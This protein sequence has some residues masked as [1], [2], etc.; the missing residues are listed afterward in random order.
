MYSVLI[1]HHVLRC[2]RIDLKQR[3]IKNHFNPKNNDDP[4]QTSDDD[5]KPWGEPKTL[6]D[7]DSEESE[8]QR[9]Q[10]ADDGGRKERKKVKRNAKRNCEKNKSYREASSDEEDLLTAKPRKQAKKKGESSAGMF[11]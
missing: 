7:T 1:P 3:Y 5:G 9:K 11:I 10:L 6:L 8:A 4:Y 2:H